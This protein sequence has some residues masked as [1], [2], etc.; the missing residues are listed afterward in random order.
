MKWR[1]EKNNW[2]ILNTHRNQRKQQTSIAP[3]IDFDVMKRT[4]ERWSRTRTAPK[5]KK[6]KKKKT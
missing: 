6:K 2:K 3:T 1:E 5:V 4:Q